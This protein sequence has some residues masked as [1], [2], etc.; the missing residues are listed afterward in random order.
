MAGKLA[1]LEQFSQLY[2]FYSKLCELE[3]DCSHVGQLAS[4]V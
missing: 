1:Y 3:F 2:S 4:S